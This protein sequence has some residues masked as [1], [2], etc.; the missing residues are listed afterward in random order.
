MTQW[1][2]VCCK[3]CRDASRAHARIKTLS[4]RVR[5]CFVFGELGDTS[6]VR[7]AGL[8]T[9]AAQFGYTFVSR[10]RR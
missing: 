9:P 1:P 2:H 7:C 6:A 5:V 8:E 4:A 3:H 10:Q